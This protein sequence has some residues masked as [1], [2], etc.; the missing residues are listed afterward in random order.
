[1][2][3]I[4]LLT[5]LLALIAVSVP[6][7]PLTV[8]E[9]SNLIASD[10]A[11]G[12]ADGDI[13]RD[14]SRVEMRER[15][16]ES[17]LDALRGQGI[18]PKTAGVL[19]LLKDDSEFLESG[20]ASREPPPAPPSADLDSILARVRDYAARYVGA[21]PDFVCTRV[22]R[23]FDNR[24]TLK[25]N[26]WLRLGALHQE[27]TITDRVSFE[28]GR[29]VD[30]QPLAG[31]SD[32][33]E[34][35]GVLSSI[36][37][38]DVRAEMQWDRW[39]TVA[40]QRLAVFRYS[41]DADHSQHTV[42]WCCDGTYRREIRP[43][44][45]GELFIEPVSGG[46]MRVTR[47][48]ILPP[49]F[50][51]QRADTLVEYG[52]VDIVGRSYLCPTKSVT[53]SLWK[54]GSASFVNSLNE[55]R[56][57]S[58]HQPVGPQPDI[59]SEPFPPAPTVTKST[60]AVGTL[61]R[62][63]TRIVDVSTVVFD[64][65]GDPVTN[66]TRKDFQI[67]DQGELRKI[68]LFSAPA[69]LEVRHWD[70]HRENA[71]YETR[72][73]AQRPGRFSNREDSLRV[74]P[75]TIILIDLGT[76]TPDERASAEGR[77]VKVLDQVQSQRI[78][79]YAPTQDGVGTIHELNQSPSALVGQFE[80]WYR[81]V[82]LQR[83]VVSPNCP[84][85]QA[86]TA[87]ARSADHVASIAGRKS[88]I[89]VSGGH[90]LRTPVLL[91]GFGALPVPEAPQDCFHQENEAA[92]AANVANVSVYSIDLRGLQTLQPDAS[93]PSH[94]DTVP[95]SLHGGV[96]LALAALEK[97]HSIMREVAEDTGGR[98]FTETN[99]IL[100]SLRSALTET[101]AA[102]SLGFYL[103]PPRFDGR[104]RRLEVRVRG[105]P[106]LSV[107]YRR[108]YVDAPEPDPDQQLKEAVDNP[109]DAN[110]IAVSAQI[111]DRKKDSY[112]LKL[113][114]GVK[115]LDLQEDTGHRRGLIRLFVVRR[116]ESG[117]Q[118]DH[119]DETLR[120]DFNLERYE[121]LGKAGLEHHLAIQPNPDGASLRIVVRD[122]AGNLGSLTVP[123]SPSARN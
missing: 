13:A 49:Q 107:R 121:T 90:Q 106:D 57:S 88:L 40:G 113:R 2:T 123:L 19:E 62:V 3:R 78:G 54:V 94:Q 80:A 76:S 37:S 98:S 55:A 91:P 52:S 104:Y 39:E 64:H 60:P 112:D 11:G 17:A 101:D 74:D 1:M 30:G 108:G 68:S 7:A 85:E 29:E 102:Y 28:A 93:E 32:W 89:W 31:L 10:L 115:D 9:L 100:G 33:G 75:A 15:L 77:I 84:A 53:I 72:K 111:A 97:D 120:L 22:V 122:E 51:T 23:R 8:R 67:L 27:D 48:A 25:V 118:L 34:F 4:V 43:G 35:G 110:E 79:L 70:Q 69:P 116:D 114:I 12:K 50:P 109:L 103:Q 45:K 38:P 16:T 24:P 87:I 119:W 66:L 47:Q 63:T 117:R 58:Y 83:G 82:A 56:Y 5:A 26:E 81:E 92:R 96:P 65:R 6:A 44:Y 21:L 18:G 36:L 105:R 73:L 41:V 59:H 86:L 71:E 42:V 14:V 95:T 46:V 99:D 61:L 20:D